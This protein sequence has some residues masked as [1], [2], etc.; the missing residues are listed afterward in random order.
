M[1]NSKRKYKPAG[2]PG[3]NPDIVNWSYKPAVPGKSKNKNLTVKV[4]EEMLVSVK[5]LPDWSNKVRAKLEEL[6]E[7]ERGGNAVS[8]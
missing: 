2:R 7:E 8:G 6:L 4:D 3:G 5:S 1:S